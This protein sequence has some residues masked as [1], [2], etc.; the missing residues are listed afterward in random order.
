MRQFNQQK[1]KMT[2]IFDRRAILCPLDGQNA[3]VVA[4][5]VARLVDAIGLL[6][7]TASPRISMSWAPRTDASSSLLKRVPDESREMT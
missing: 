2:R 6:W 4:A 7:P 1:S 3:K 5:L